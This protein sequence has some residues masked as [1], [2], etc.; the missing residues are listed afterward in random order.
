MSDRN[1]KLLVSDI[2]ESIEKI[3]R[4]TAGLSFD[5]FIK[6]EIIVDAVVRNFTIIGEATAR[7]PKSFK[8][9][10]KMIPWLKI[11]NF[12]NILTHEY[13]GIDLKITWLIVQKELPFLFT[14]LSEIY[15]SMPDSLFDSE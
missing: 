1:S 14:S 6:S 12:R 2:I 11:K 4:Y 9:G 15:K 10:N 8:S 3:N 5:E 7:L 13:F